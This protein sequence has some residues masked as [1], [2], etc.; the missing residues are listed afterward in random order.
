MMRALVLVVAVLSASC[1][2][3]PDPPPGARSVEE[4][5][6]E[7]GA[8]VLEAMRRGYVPGR[9]GELALIPRPHHVIVRRGSWDPG[10]E[11][12]PD[13]S[14]S[15]PWAYHQRVP[16]LLYG[17]GFVREG[18]VSERAVDLADLA[19]TLAELMGFPFR[20]RDGVPLSEALAPGQRG[21][22]RAIALV[23]YDGG[24]WNLLQA[25]PGDWPF[26]R[27][28][29]A[30]GALF[31]NATVG[32]SPSVTAAVHPTMGTGAYPAAHGVPDNSARLP[33]GTVG[34]AYLGR[35]DPRLLRVE[36]L[37][38]A[39]HEAT[40]AWTGIVATESWHLGMLGRGAGPGAAPE[41]VA[42]LW[43]RRERRFFTNPERYRLPG[44]LPAEDSLEA[45][46]R[47]LDGSDGS[48]DGRWMGND[49]EDPGVLPGTPA[50]V[51]YQGD[52]VLRILGRERIGRDD[53]T[54][55]LF[56]ELK[57]TDRGA[58][59]WNMVG[60]EQ[61]HV[62]RAQDDLLRDVAAALDAEVGEGRWVLAVTADHGLT[63]LPE[64]VGGVRL[65]PDALAAAVEERLG[66]IVEAATPSSLFLDMDEVRSRDL[67][68]DLVATIVGDLRYRDGIPEGVDLERI[69][70]DLLDRR[71]FAAVLP[72][73]Y[74][75][76]LT[77]EETARAGLGIYE[78]GDLTGVDAAARFARLAG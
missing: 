3:P 50:F 54:D 15:T 59:L 33:D 56:V 12:S 11:P 28:L 46:L 22:P 17:P 71:V 14:H 1:S 73:P 13:T 43:N 27:A 34:D 42:V 78:E 66:P 63:P 77:A 57:S 9:S 60:E 23:A 41:Q 2:G 19:P 62:L 61:P 69:P 55:L 51:R 16:I 64:E 65:H 5:A 25:Y 31:T 8:D 29:M 76:G 52:A 45:R 36:T 10:G 68:L 44:Y 58:H 70:G 24:G 75:E 38:D 37:A 26:L 48:L 21:A 74:L 30:R 53:I 20:A 32:S 6:R 18:T 4:M 35:T 67:D 7:V 40:G 72:G 49:L 47:E 39:W